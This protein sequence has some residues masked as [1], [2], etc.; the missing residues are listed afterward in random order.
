MILTLLAL[1]SCPVWAIDYRAI[2]L[3]A[4]VGADSTAYGINDHGLIV[5]QALWTAC[6]W[7]HGSY[8]DLGLLNS[9]LQTTA[10]AIN[11]RGQIVGE[12]LGTTGFLLGQNG[13]TNLGDFGEYMTT[14]ESLPAA[15]NS[16]G[17]VVGTA[18]MG[19]AMCAFAWSDGVMT[20]LGTLGGDSQANGVS[21]KG[22]VVGAACTS[23]YDYTAAY[24]D[25]LA[26][27][28]LG[29]FGNECSWSMGVN[30]A[31]TI[32]G[33]SGSLS[34][35]VND[36]AFSYSNGQATDLGPGRAYAINSNGWIAGVQGRP[37][38]GTACVWVNGIPTL[39]GSMGGW[40]STALAI[41]SEGDVV[42][43]ADDSV[44]SRHA[45]LWVLVPE[46]SGIA[47]LA[48]GLSVMGVI[49]MTRHVCSRCDG[50]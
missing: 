14:Q 19:D 3:P 37:Q 22:R 24:W 28:T 38:L 32:V 31:G 7:D 11:D 33:Y 9:G 27:H 13:F 18:E 29:T 50:I 1:L 20:A 49:L 42:G 43:W 25:G 40:R 30:D 12:R 4:P 26:I 17:E 6:T 16:S 36:R 34:D 45:M 21:N 23:W 2:Q 10:S 35:D 41:N 47:A 46:P 8:C 39:L 44:G 15:I 48:F 5:G